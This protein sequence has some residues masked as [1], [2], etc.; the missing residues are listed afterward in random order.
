MGRYIERTVQ[1][2]AVDYLE[3]RYRRRARRGRV[4]SD[5]EVRTRKEHGGNRA[6]GLLAFRH[7][8]WG[9]YVVS[10][11][12]KSYKTI[13]AMRPKVSPL[14]FFWNSLRAG[15]VVAIISGALFLSGQVKSTASPFA[16]PVGVMLIGSIAY[17]VMTRKSF[18]H[19]KA[20]VIDQVQ[21]YPAN[22][23]WLAFS[24][25]SLQDLSPQKYN[26]LKKLARSHGIGILIVKPGHKVDIWLR[27]GKKR[28]WIG[29]FLKFYSV[30]EDVRKFLGR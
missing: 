17:G 12:A 19:R 7:W 16:L 14:L 4:Y 1:L 11:E 9:T 2:V 26:N 21:R 27:P 18:S 28:K 23:Q 5:I 22:E 25:D 3:R 20:E 10:M 15:I 13:P 24:E 8:L 29:D 6:D 30:E